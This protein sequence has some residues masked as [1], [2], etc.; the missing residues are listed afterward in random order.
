MD[1]WNSVSSTW[2]SNRL[3]VLGDSSGSSSATCAHDIYCFGKV[4][5]ELVT[6]KLGISR[7]NDPTSTEWLDHTLR[8]IGMYNKDS[9]TKIIDPS[10]VLDEDFIQE[11]WATMVIAKSCL[12]PKP[13]RR[14]LARY[15]LKALENPLKVMRIYSS[16]S[17]AGLRTSSSRTSWHGAFY[18]SWRH[19]SSDIALGS[20]PLRRAGTVRSQGSL[21]ENSFS[22]KARHSTEIF[23]EP[24]GEAPGDEDKG[25]WFF[26]QSWISLG[27][28]Q[29]YRGL[30]LSIVECVELSLGDIWWCS[31]VLSFHRWI[32]GMHSTFV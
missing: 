29:T 5:L 32:A 13:S 4:L 28:P 26:M 14:P 11:A 2:G 1:I 7:S 25:G 22:R 12:H 27:N 30:L 20:G 9:V 31:F 6:G 19:S 10:L 23:P 16:S 21:G 24:A 8:C 3:F 15:V 18:G 17:Y